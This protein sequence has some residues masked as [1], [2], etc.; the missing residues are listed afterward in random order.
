MTTMSVRRASRETRPA[1]TRPTQAPAADDKAAAEAR[2]VMRSRGEASWPK[3]CSVASLRVTDDILVAIRSN[4]TGASQW[5][6]RVLRQLCERWIS[7]F[8]QGLDAYDLVDAAIVENIAD[9]LSPA[10]SSGEVSLRLA[11]SLNRLRTS[12]KREMRRRVDQSSIEDVV[13][14]LA[15]NSEAVLTL[16][17]LSDVLS[18][19]QKKVLAL[20]ASGFYPNE[21]SRELN[22]TPR[23]V[24][25][26]IHG[27][28]QEIE[29]KSPSRSSA[30]SGSRRLDVGRTEIE[31]VNDNERIIDRHPGASIVT[32][33]LVDP[34]LLKAL[35]AHP[36]LLKILDSRVF[37]KL[38]AEILSMLGYE[39][40]LQQGTKDGG[41]D[42]FAIKHCGILGPHRYLLQAKRWEAPVGVEPVR[43]LLF[44]HSYH[45]ITKS[46]L[47]TTSRFTR[48]AWQLASEYK[49]HLELR[50]YERLQEWVDLA[51]KAKV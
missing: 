19:G 9:L 51:L 17:E 1:G 47:A 7:V 44:L 34:S 41:V 31:Q 49:W 26:T 36:Q 45:K 50:D 30:R 27:I 8:G 4:D 39:V 43:E 6:W 3:E 20:L 10:V 14:T 25:K 23:A 42:I 24:A 48:G 12:A 29:R 13:V 33:D 18:A 37:E 21:I 40:E 28:R 16:R 11:R 35:H 32:L 22:L 15:P 5:G 46:C 2:A 38:L